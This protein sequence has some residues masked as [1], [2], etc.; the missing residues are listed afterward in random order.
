MCARACTYVCVY[1][2]PCFL[3]L[4]IALYYAQCDGFLQTLRVFQK[5]F[6]YPKANS[7]VKANVFLPVTVPLCMRTDPPV[8]YRLT[9][10]SDIG[11]LL[12]RELSVCC[13]A[14]IQKSHACKALGNEYSMHMQLSVIKNVK[15]RL[16][17][18]RECTC[19]LKLWR[20]RVNIFAV[21]K[22][23]VLYILCVFVW[24]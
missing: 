6:L 5:P 24:P 16:I 19:K 2:V 22:Q 3:C 9:C 12:H 4:W 20:V 13:K 1:S 10:K 17:Q 11:I 18:S 15:L 8:V 14:C 23:Y 7:A 21:E